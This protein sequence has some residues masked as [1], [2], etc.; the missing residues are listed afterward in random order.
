MPD[1]VIVRQRSNFD[2]QFFA[3]DPQAPEDEV[4]YPAQQ[5][6]SLTPYG[7]M[8]AGLGS[9]TALV[10][11]TYAQNHGIPVDEV[12]IR[13]TYKRNFKEDCQNCEGIEKYEEQIVEEITCRGN[14]NQE[15]QGKLLRIAHACP[16]YKMY[17]SGIEIQSYYREQMQNQFQAINP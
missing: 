14:F 1:S 11:H 12:E 8:L 3:L 2:T 16:I 17:Q 9:C 5:I 7:M 4:Y 15:I 13:L 6:H 10:I